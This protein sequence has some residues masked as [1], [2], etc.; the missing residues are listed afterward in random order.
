MNHDDSCRCW[1]PS[2]K[3]SIVAVKWLKPTWHATDFSQTDTF[4]VANTYLFNV[5]LSIRIKSYLSHQRYAFY[6]RIDLSDHIVVFHIS[7]C[8]KKN[9]ER[10]KARNILRIIFL[11]PYY[12]QL[13][14]FNQISVL[15]VFIDSV[16][17]VNNE[18]RL[19]ISIS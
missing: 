7:E 16:H 15:S 3:N 2:F 13:K 8:H 18:H 6:V 5:L 1:W 9:V 12:K 11:W 10:E 17:W 14:Y 19:I 4:F